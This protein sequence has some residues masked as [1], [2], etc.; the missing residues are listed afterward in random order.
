MPRVPKKDKATAYFALL[1]TVTSHLIN[2]CH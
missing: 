2:H 1:H